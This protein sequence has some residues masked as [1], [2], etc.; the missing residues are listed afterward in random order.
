MF[1]MDLHLE[2]VNKHF[3]EMNS[4][5]GS[6]VVWNVLHNIGAGAGAGSGPGVSQCD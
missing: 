4:G 2:H 3:P 5:P 6:G 1:Y